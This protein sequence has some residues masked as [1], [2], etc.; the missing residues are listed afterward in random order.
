MRSL[1]PPK[2]SGTLGSVAAATVMKDIVMAKIFLAV[3][4]EPVPPKLRYRR[5][6]NVWVASM[7]VEMWRCSRG[8]L[9][10]ARRRSEKSRTKT[11]GGEAS[12]S[13]ASP[14]FLYI[15]SNFLLRDLAVK[16]S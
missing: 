7:V 15:S 3:N 13:S 12:S 5:R 11:E 2:S 6:A 4:E 10:G 14:T 8:L 9:C 1:F 16:A